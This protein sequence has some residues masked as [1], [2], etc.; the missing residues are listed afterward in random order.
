[1]VEP[2]LL[3]RSAIMQYK[4]IKSETIILIFRFNQKV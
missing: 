1:M 2:F 4:K 3:L